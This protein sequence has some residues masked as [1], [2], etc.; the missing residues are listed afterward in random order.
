[1]DVDSGIV[2]IDELE[3]G[4]VQPEQTAKVEVTM[5]CLTDNEST[6]VLVFLERQTLRRKRAPLVA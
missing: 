1:M 4:I 6:C 3:S 2:L 5:K